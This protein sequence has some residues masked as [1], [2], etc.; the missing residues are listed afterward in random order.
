MS[1]HALFEQEIR[2]YLAAD[3]DALLFRQGF[4]RA[5][6]TKLYQRAIGQSQQVINFHFEVEPRDDPSKELLIRPKIQ[7]SLPV[8]T[9]MAV[10]LSGGSPLILPAPNLPIALPV[11]PNLIKSVKIG[12]FA[13][14][15]G[16]RK[17]AIEAGGAA[18][19]EHGLAFVEKITTI[20]DLIVFFEKKEKGLR[21]DSRMMIFIIAAYVLS[22]HSKKAVDLAQKHFN[23]AGMLKHYGI[24]LENLDV[25]LKGSNV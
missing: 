25:V 21:M 18:I 1:R 12:W 5:P 6:E 10:K 20:E 8:L 4:T 23:R 15:A 2:S 14:G 19:A 3:L 11:S 13:S 16:A 24:V 17:K 22:R 9:Q 7:I